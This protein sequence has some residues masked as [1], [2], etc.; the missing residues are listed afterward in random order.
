MCRQTFQSS[1]D[2]R[3]HVMSL[4]DKISKMKGELKSTKKEQTRLDGVTAD[5]KAKAVK[6]EANKLKLKEIIVRL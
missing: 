3:H 4:E 1:L 2:T 6:L 5:E